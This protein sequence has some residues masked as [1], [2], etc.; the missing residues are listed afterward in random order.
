MI[1]LYSDDIKFCIT[2]SRQGVKLLVAE[3]TVY[4]I[5]VV[6]SGWCECTCPPR[7]GETCYTFPC[8]SAN[9]SRQHMNL[10]GPADRFIA[11][12]EPNN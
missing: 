8:A 5:A 7:S 11:S 10:K 9:T 6:V 12:N 4:R 1:V 3:G 2:F